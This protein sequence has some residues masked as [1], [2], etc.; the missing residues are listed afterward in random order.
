[1]QG[2]VGSLPS[3]VLLKTISFPVKIAAVALDPGEYVFY[4]ACSD[5]NI[6]IA[7]LNSG[8]SS[9]GSY[10]RDIIGA[11]SDH[12]EAVTCLALSIDGVTLVSGSK[13]RTIRIWHPMTRQV[14][15]ILKH[16]KDP[17]SNILVIKQPSALSSTLAPKRRALPPLLQR[18]VTA[19]VGYP[20]S[21]YET[22]P[23]VSLQHQYIE[24]LDSRLF[25]T[26]H[27]LKNQ[28][29]EFEKHDS[30][31]KV[32]RDLEKLKSDYSRSRQM[33]KSWKNMY[34]DLHCFC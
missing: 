7:A 16:D 5:A 34:E 28:I 33:I 21:S 20:D 26:L 10:G 18:Y 25:T 14:L 30:L 12:S 6:Y 27:V 11:L 17:V 1:L 15:H 29:K 8:N 3:G 32:Q 2:Q 9:G 4:A 31:A 19:E 24:S 22:G 23:V 13:D